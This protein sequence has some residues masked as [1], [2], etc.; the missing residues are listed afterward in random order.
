LSIE[1]FLPADIE[2]AAIMRRVREQGEV[3]PEARPHVLVA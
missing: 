3:R 2:T 1:A